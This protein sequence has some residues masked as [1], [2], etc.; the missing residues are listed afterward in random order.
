MLLKVFSWLF[1]RGRRV[2][3][4]LVFDHEIEK[5]AKANRKA[6]RLARKA[7]RLASV[8]QDISEEVVS[9]PHTSDDETNIMAAHNPA[10]PPPP[11]RRTL[12]DYGQRNNGEFANLGFQPA[13]P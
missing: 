3:R 5:T 6:A 2:V 10:P 8:T 7:A 13:N 9:S 1:M 12:G 4:V 11:P